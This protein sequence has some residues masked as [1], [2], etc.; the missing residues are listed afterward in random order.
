MAYVEV[1][2]NLDEVQTKFAFGLTWQQLLR[3]VIGGGVGIGFYFLTKDSLGQGVASAGL[4]VLGAPIIVSGF[5]KKDGMSLG[6]Y[7][8]L[9]F[10]KKFTPKT[11]IYMTNNKYKVKKGGA[12]GK[13]TK[14]HKKAKG[15]K[16]LSK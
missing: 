14:D 9:I 4:M 7:L 3:I 1:P 16:K 2:A 10:R 15:A 8:K 12:N 13:A 5:Y 11:R 6:K